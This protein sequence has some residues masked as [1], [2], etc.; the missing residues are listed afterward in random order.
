MVRTALMKLSP[1]YVSCVHQENDTTDGECGVER[2][3]LQALGGS[4]ETPKEEGR[5]GAFPRAQVM[6]H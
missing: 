3:G 6:E 2:G 1:K 4:D 5:E